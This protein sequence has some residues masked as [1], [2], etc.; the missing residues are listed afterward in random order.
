MSD[1][2]GPNAPHEEP[3]HR[4]TRSGGNARAARVARANRL[5]V[6]CVSLF[7]AFSGNTLAQESAF[8]QPARN[9]FPQPADRPGLSVQGTSLHQK[10]WADHDVSYLRGE[11]VLEHD[12]QRY[13]CAEILMSVTGSGR[14]LTAHVLM[15]AVELGDGRTTQKP[16]VTTLALSDV[17]RIQSDRYTR[18]KEPPSGWLP[19]IGIHATDSSPDPQSRAQSAVAPVI[20]QVAFEQ[21][22]NSTELTPPPLAVTSPG[23]TLPS[24]GMVLPMENTRQRAPSGES[25][26]ATPVQSFA[27]PVDGTTLPGGPSLNSQLPPPD[28]VSNDAGVSGAQFFIGDGTRSLDFYGRGTTQP[29]N[30]SIPLSAD[31]TE[32]IVIARGGVTVVVRDV[33]ARLPSGPLMSF[34]DVSLSADRIVAWVP[35]I[36]QVLRGDQSLSG[37]EGEMYLE[38]DIVF[39]Q[40]DRVIYADAMYYNA[41]RE[42]GVILEAEAVATVDE[43]HGVVRLKSEV[44]KQVASGN[45]VAFNAAVTTS[46]MGVPRYWLQSNRLELFQRPITVADEVTQQP[47]LDSESY[48]SSRGNFVYLAGFP[49]LYW[50]TFRAPLQRPTFYLRGARLENDDIFGTQVLLEWDTFQLLGLTNPPAGVESVLLTDYLSERGPAIGNRITWDRA[51]LFGFGGRAV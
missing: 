42:V 5:L 46:R 16:V 12:G 21:S 13:R 49:V 39:R 50:P 34:G 24:M 37:I 17:P 22:T 9:G 8:P 3:P 43:L 44:M 51:N 41:E 33:T 47:R 35:P 31:T 10:R 30:L 38:G 4:E 20:A 36:G 27:P 40:G 6:A 1:A 26:L 28:T 45:F 14:D 2:S 23:Q 19:R 11:C 7:L 29:P 48:L 15:S 18:W 32:S 25:V